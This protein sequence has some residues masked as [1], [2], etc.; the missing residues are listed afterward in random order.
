MAKIVMTADL[1]F[2][3]AG[4]LNDIL[5]ASR[6]I[7]EYCKA[8]NIDTILVLGDLFHD[9]KSIEIDVLSAATKFFEECSLQYGQQWIAFP[10][11]HDMYLR[12]SWDI[13]SLTVMKKHLTI[14]EDIKILTIDDARFWVVPF[15]TYE[16][17]YMKVIDEIEKQYER[18]DI[19][20]THI[21]VRGSTL[22]TCFLLKDWSTIH[23]EHSKFKRIYTGHF[24]SKQQVGLNVYYPGSPIPFKFDE[25][26]VPHGFYVYDTD[27]KDHKF[28][29]IWKAGEKLL[30]GEPQ[31]PQYYT[32]TNEV[33]ADV[34]EDDIKNGMVRVALL[35]HH[36]AEEKFKIKDQLIQMGARSVRWMDQTQKIDTQTIIAAKP[37]KNLFQAWIDQDKTGMKGLDVKILQRIND[38]IIQEGDEHYSVEESD[39]S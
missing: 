15:I 32:I 21:G 11:N 27:T 22:N 36:T 33:L 10:G 17:P 34:T 30:P 28:I 4:R 20:L 38:E 14:V 31:P 37:N 5:W 16:K 23:F 7:R 3:V 18:D 9:R 26:D 8:A 24:H 39:I 2:G 1:H 13:N 29:N 6:V 19:L 12:H 35:R 25:G